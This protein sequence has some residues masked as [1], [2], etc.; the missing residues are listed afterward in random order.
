MR[1]ARLQQRVGSK[2]EYIEFF[3]SARF[4]PIENIAP[5]GFG[6]P[7]RRRTAVGVFLERLNLLS[8]VVK[9]SR[10]P[11]EISQPTQE[12]PR[13]LLLHPMGL[14]LALTQLRQGL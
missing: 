6:L 3:K 2:M 4:I 7:E 11:A 13:G 1:G 12:H 8:R 14:R 9:W 10:P 5:R